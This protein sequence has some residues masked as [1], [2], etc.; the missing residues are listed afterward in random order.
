M[1]ASTGALASAVTVTIPADDYYLTAAGGVSS[2]IDTLEDELNENVRQY[3]DNSSSVTAMLGYGNFATGA[4]W[5][6]QQ[7][8]TPLTATFGS[9]NLT[10]VSTPTYQNAGPQSGK[11]AIG[12]NSDLDSFSGGDAFDVTDTDDFVLM[13]VAKFSS[14]PAST[15]DFINKITTAAGWHVYANTNGTYTFRG[16]DAGPTQLFASTGADMHVGSW[17]VGIA[18]I[19]RAT[20]KARIGTRSLA[21]VSSVASEATT[22]ATTMANAVAFQVGDDASGSGNAPTTA[23]I[24]GVWVVSGASVATGLSAN[25][26]TALTNFAAAINASWTVSMSSTTGLVSIS[27]A[28]WPCAVD[29]TSTDARDCL[30]YAYD[31]N[32][33]NTAAQM[34][35]ALGGTWTSGAGYLCN[36]TSGDL[37]SVFGTPATLPD[38]STPTYAGVGAR[39]GVDKCVGFDSTL[40]QFSDASAFSVGA[41]DDL[42]VAWVGK[43]ADSSGTRTTTISKLSG[44]FAD[45]W[46][47]Y[48]ST[49][50]SEGPSFSVQV[51]GGSN[52]TATTG[53]TGFLL[54]EWHVGIATIDRSTGKIRIGLQGL[55]SGTAVVSSEVTAAGSFASSGE[56]SLGRS[57]WVNADTNFKL[58]AV[59]VTSGSGVA[60][61]LS[62]GLSTALSSFAA[63]MKAQTSTQQAKGLWFPDA[64]LSCDDHPSM[65]PPESDLRATESPTGVVLGLSGNEKFVH[66]NVGWERSPVDRIREA[67][68]TYDNASFEVFWRDAISGVGGH[69]WLGPCSALQ[70][71]WN[72]AGNLELLGSDA[73]DGAGVAGWKPVG[74]YKFTD[75]VKVSQKNWVGQWDVRFPRL[76]S[77]GS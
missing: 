36:E 50:G 30:G 67:S 39:G 34:A 24:A 37:A 49:I 35:T 63:Y 72:N 21:G 29:F 76:V 19:D 10:A 77:D 16:F 6:M 45:G 46:V 13:W 60:T 17:H 58:S 57:A 53:L 74:V 42:I 71:Y 27:H 11:Y 1:S 61:G 43:Y 32:Y 48:S 70:I 18:T 28:W 33:P 52:Y 55:R 44:A 40:D 20:G 22:A 66:T 75:V 47:L 38:T 25:M 7:S 9:P 41:S 8:A 73:N 23:T 65:A 64:P 2:L 56:F 5:L 69:D 4:A 54:N 62:A 3:P 51:N 14:A 59:Y 31:F 26:S 12:F 15:K 68:A